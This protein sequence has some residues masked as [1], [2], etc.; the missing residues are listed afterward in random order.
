[1][2]PVTPNT[3]PGSGGILLEIVTPEGPAYRGRAR[4]VELPTVDGELGIFPGHIRLFAEVGVGEIRA[5]AENE[6][7]SFAVAGGY[8]Q[9]GPESVRVVA[10]FVSAGEEEARIEDA[11]RR[12]REALTFADGLSSE[13]L[14]SDLVALRIGLLRG[15]K[16]Q[17]AAVS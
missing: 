14:E 8:V 3:L 11:C 17:P 5:H 7:S 15:R 9:I 10:Y 4:F 6:L 13:R 12:A 2:A 16:G 1:M